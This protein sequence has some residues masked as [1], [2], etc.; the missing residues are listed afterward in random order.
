V[1]VTIG[2]LNFL[3]VIV[4]VVC[5][6]SYKLPCIETLR[7][8]LDATD[9]FADRFYDESTVQMRRHART[10]DATVGTNMSNPLEEVER[11]EA[12]VAGEAGTVTGTEAGTETEAA[13]A[14]SAVVATEAAV[15]A[16]VEAAPV[17]TLTSSVKKKAKRK[18][19]GRKHRGSV[20]NMLQKR[21]ERRLTEVDSGSGGGGGSCGGS[22]D[23]DVEEQRQK[24]GI[25][26]EVELSVVRKDRAANQNEI[27]QYE[28]NPL[29]KNRSSKGARSSELVVGGEVKTTDCV[30][31]VPK[32]R[33]PIVDERSKGG[34]RTHSFEDMLIT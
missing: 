16:E 5:F 21:L 7:N 23:G 20:S 8:L 12:A 28:E 15:D 32:D 33:S 31:G 2:G 9:R 13:M 4:L 27:L 26:K 18:T 29:K 17:A 19:K 34:T 10:F 11:I 24:K 25:F 30:V 1:S 22:S 14:E 3:L 6:L